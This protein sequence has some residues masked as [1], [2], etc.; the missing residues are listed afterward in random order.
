MLKRS[1]YALLKSNNVL[2][3][4]YTEIK[5]LLKLFYLQASIQCVDRKTNRAI[6]YYKGI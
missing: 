3:V 4:D 2:V 6:S 5:T 1:K